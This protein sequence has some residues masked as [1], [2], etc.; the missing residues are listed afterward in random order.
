MGNWTFNGIDAETGEYLLPA[1]RSQQVS[2]LAQGEKLDADTLE[3]SR[4]RVD[5][6][7]PHYGVKHGVD[8]NNLAQAGWGIIFAADAGEDVRVALRPL[9]EMRKD[10]A[11]ERYREYVGA[12]GYQPNDS[13]RAWLG[14]PPREK[15]L[16]PADPDSVP[17][18][19]LIV[20]DPEA[21]PFR[22]QYELDVNYAVGRICFDHVD[23]YRAYAESVVNAENMQRRRAVSRRAMFYG[24]RNPDD[25]ATGLSAD[26]LILPLSQ[27]ISGKHADAWQVDTFIGDTA[28]K[29]RLHETFTSGATPSLLFTATHGIGFRCGDPLQIERQG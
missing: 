7:Q 12:L 5:S 18:Y 3:V 19:L 1:L 14:R 21:I 15:G 10:Q 17:F 28:T 16:G 20:G 6:A 2:A 26:Y 25:E 13:L 11:K 22:F 29:Q 27:T 23:D 9:L 4:A 24:T 8:A